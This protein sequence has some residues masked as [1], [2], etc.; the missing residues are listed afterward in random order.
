ME[1]ID[2]LFGFRKGNEN[3]F[4]CPYSVFEM[5]KKTIF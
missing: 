4:I 5:K 2:K 3:L 1:N